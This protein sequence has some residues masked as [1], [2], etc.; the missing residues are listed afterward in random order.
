M[1]LV[2]D[3]EFARRAGENFA[4]VI[5]APWFEVMEF[6]IGDTE[7]SIAVPPGTIITNIHVICVALRNTGTSASLQVG[8]ETDPDGYFTAVDLKA[9][10][11]LAGQSINFYAP[12]GQNGAYLLTPGSGGHVLSNYYAAADT[13]TATIADTGTAPTTGEH[14]VVVEML[15]FNRTV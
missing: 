11:L 9:T 12:G 5:G 4:P 13:I 2:F 6:G 1:P 3:T 10:D 14:Y 15:T 7:K 8:D